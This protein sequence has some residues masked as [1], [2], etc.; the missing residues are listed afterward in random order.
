[1]QVGISKK[2][3]LTIGS[4]K[5]T[6]WALMNGYMYHTNIDAIIQNATFAFTPPAK[7]LKLGKAGYTK[8][9]FDRVSY[10]FEHFGILS[11]SFENRIVQPDFNCFRIPP[12]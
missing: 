1:V 9:S 12:F 2:N 3:V 11:I 8:K 6:Q 10:R 7:V 5:A 4:H